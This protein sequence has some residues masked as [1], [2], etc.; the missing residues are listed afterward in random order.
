MLNRYVVELEGNRNV[1][2]LG[3]HDIP[4]SVLIDTKPEKILDRLRDGLLAAHPGRLLSEEPKKKGF[5][6][7]RECRLA[8]NSGLHIRARFY[9]IRER[10]YQLLIVGTSSEADSPMA[11]QFFNS[12]IP[13]P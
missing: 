12:F 11:Q 4:K 6:P 3:W 7:G 1:Y 5:F 8:S 10:V 13:K 2:T 9:L